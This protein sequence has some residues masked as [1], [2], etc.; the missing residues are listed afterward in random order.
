MSLNWKY[1][2]GKA[3]FS[4]M[5]MAV[6]FGAPSPTGLFLNHDLVRFLGRPVRSVIDVGA[7]VGDTVAEYLSKFQDCQIH[8]LE[9]VSSNFKILSDRFHN[10]TRVT[11]HPLAL[12][13]ETGTKVIN[14]WRNRE[15]HSFSRQETASGPTESVNITTLDAWVA[16]EKISSVDL[17]KIDAEGFEMSIVKGADQF[18]RKGNA[19]AV[20]VEVGF[21][22]GDIGKTHFSAMDD[23]LVDCGFIFSGFYQFLRWGERKQK[24]SFANGLWLWHTLK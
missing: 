20:F 16:E 15:Y 17:L 9:P 18:L 10:H 14:L 11:L 21:I 1:H 2:I 19:L 23:F 3:T 4:I 6:R 22:H 5:D 7:N 24:A 13:A 12:G 8:A